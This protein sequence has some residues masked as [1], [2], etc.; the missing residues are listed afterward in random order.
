[1]FLIFHGP[2][3]NRH[4]ATAIEYTAINLDHFRGRYWRDEP[5]RRRDQSGAEQRRDRRPARV[6]RP[7]ADDRAALAKPDDVRGWRI[8]LGHAE[9]L[10]S[11]GP[12]TAS[13]FWWAASLLHFRGKQ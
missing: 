8:G 13:L 4:G 6:E 9:A 10:F 1:M 11:N 3:K 12:A 7:A 2:M 5:P